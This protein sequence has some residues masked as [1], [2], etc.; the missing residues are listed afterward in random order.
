[1]PLLPFSLVE[2]LEYV[3]DTVVVFGADC[4]YRYINRIGAQ[5]LGRTAADIIGKKLG[6]IFPPNAA[7]RQL[8]ALHEVLLT[9]KPFATDLFHIAGPREAWFNVRL[10]PI[11]GADGKPEKVL[12]FIRNVTD[13]YRALEAVQEKEQYLKDVLENASDGIVWAERLSMKILHVNR[14]CERMFGWRDAGYAGKTI[15]DLHPADRADFYRAAFSRHASGQSNYTQGEVVCADGRQR[16]VSISSSLTCYQGREVVIGFFR[17]T[18]EPQ[19][20]K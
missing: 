12:G 14:A 17:D 3:P 10:V 5:R 9:G 4:R 8:S 18:T 20:A 15:L 6:D 1:M 13:R 2:F 11:P 19:P 7:D 16:A